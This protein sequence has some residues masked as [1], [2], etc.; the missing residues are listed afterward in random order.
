MCV[1]NHILAKFKSIGFIFL[2]L[3]LIPLTYINVQAQEDSKDVD[4][5]TII[6]EEKDKS[7]NSYIFISAGYQAPAWIRVPMTPENSPD[8]H[9]QGNMKVKVPGWFT[10]FGI[11]KKTKSRFEAGL[12]ADY[13]KSQIPVAYSGQRSTSDWVYDQNFNTGYFT[14]VFEDDILR[15]NET[16]SFRGVIRYK[17]PVH[18]FSFWGGL[19]GGTFSSRISFNEQKYVVTSL[20][21]TGQAGIDL[22]IKD[23]MDKDLFSISIFSDFAGPKIHEN[24]ISLFNPNWMYVNSDGNYSVNPFR[25][26]VSV[27]IHVK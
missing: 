16:L 10:G 13:Y 9:K 8:I 22:N 1:N 25:I 6:V 5:I 2:S 11:I 24:M 4:G 14:Q 7:K 12:L 19:T 23:S 26:G 18:N 17:I 3:L 20:G 15:V 21:A 27:G